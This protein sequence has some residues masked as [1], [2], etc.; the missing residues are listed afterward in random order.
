MQL[1]EGNA[2]MDGPEEATR[3][4]AWPAE[5]AWPRK[6]GPSRVFA[7]IQSYPGTSFRGGI[8]S[9]LYLLLHL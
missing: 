3:E 2:Q 6:R 8:R 5:M 9:G 1:P 7:A 4:S